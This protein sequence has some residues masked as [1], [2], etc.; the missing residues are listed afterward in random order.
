MPSESIPTVLRHRVRERANGLCE[1]C[2]PL[3]TSAT[4]PFTVITSSHEML[5]EKPN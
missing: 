1:Y 3:I 4:L 2:R 5:V